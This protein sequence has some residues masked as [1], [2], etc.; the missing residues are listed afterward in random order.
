MPLTSALNVYI[1]AQDLLSRLATDALE[2]LLCDVSEN[3]M[4]IFF[5]IIV[6]LFD[7][8]SLCENAMLL[9][10]GCTKL[11]Y[12]LTVQCTVPESLRWSFV[13]R[14]QG[15]QFKTSFYHMARYMNK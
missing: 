5:Y 4:Y 1:L 8:V 3:H 7:G 12:R 13:S 6:R 10:G 14:G 9:H 11:S 15:Y 2:Y